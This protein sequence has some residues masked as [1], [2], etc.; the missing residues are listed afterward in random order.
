G[1]EDGEGRAATPSD[2]TPS[3]FDAT[4]PHPPLT[5][6]LPSSQAN[7]SWI[8]LNTPSPPRLSS[9]RAQSPRNTSKTSHPSTRQ[10]T[11]AHASLHKHALHL[12]TYHFHLFSLSIR[13]H[14]NC[15]RHIRKVDVVD[16][17]NFHYTFRAIPWWGGPE[18]QAAGVEA[19]SSISI[20][21]A[22]LRPSSAAGGCFIGL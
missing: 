13:T 16:P 2:T 19:G 22:V 8:A 12:Y 21:P 11:A 4:P 5:R 14:H 20:A 7:S 9:T 6:H 1:E 18:R 15:L 3:T 17:F 10:T